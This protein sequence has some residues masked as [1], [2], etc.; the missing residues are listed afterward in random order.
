MSSEVAEQRDS[1]ELEEGEINGWKNVSQKAGRSPKQ[2]VQQDQ[3]II[4]TP[5]RFAA[6]SISRDSGV[7]SDQE[8]EDTEEGGEE[9]PIQD[10][11]DA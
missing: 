9:E 11:T 5:S 4:V 1:L 3:M 7:E 8:K 10:I 6:L 2:G